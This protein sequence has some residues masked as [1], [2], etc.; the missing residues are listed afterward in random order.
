[1]CARFTLMHPWA[2]VVRLL[3]GNIRAAVHGKPSWNVAPTHQ[4]AIIEDGNAGH[5]WP[6]RV[7]HEAADQRAVGDGRVEANSPR[8]NDAGC[9]AAVG[10]VI[11]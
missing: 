7:V 1:M 6:Q 5:I 9:A 4:S 10:A 11:R 2:E 3:G 8:N